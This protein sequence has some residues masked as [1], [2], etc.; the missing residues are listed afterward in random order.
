MLSLLGNPN[1]T[2]SWL[3]ISILTSILL[4]FCWAYFFFTKKYSEPFITFLNKPNTFFLLWR[5]FLLLFIGIS[6][7][8]FGYCFF[9]YGGYDYGLYY[10]R[11]TSY[12]I[13]TFLSWEG[14]C[15]LFQAVERALTVF[16]E[17]R[18][19]EG[20]CFFLFKE[21]F[22]VLNS[23]LKGGL[24]SFLF[25]LILSLFLFCVFKLA[26]K[27]FVTNTVAHIPKPLNGSG[28]LF[29]THCIIFNAFFL[30]LLASLPFMDA[31]SWAFLVWSPSSFF[32]GNY[33]QILTLLIYTD[34]WR[35][36][37]LVS[38]T[39]Y[40]FK[41][42]PVLIHLLRLLFLQT[43]PVLNFLICFFFFSRICDLLVTF[44]K[45]KNN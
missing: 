28:F 14:I 40:F 27:Y 41:F 15:S 10:N 35:K 44:W 33:S 23:D 9:S 7:D 22:L 20:L 21:T 18:K 36:T 32:F 31:L 13:L 5:S 30:S 45:N 34:F 17:T 6:S 25:N 42:K 2:W 4:F 19:T 43:D 8:S 37:V 38:F 29:F 39:A 11:S 26:T 16:S 12:K 1:L 24:C 3:F